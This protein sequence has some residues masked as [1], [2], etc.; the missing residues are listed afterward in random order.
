MKFSIDKTRKEL[1]L[2]KARQVSD[3]L[4]DDTRSDSEIY[5]AVLDLVYILE[6]VIK[7][8]VAEENFLLIYPKLPSE[9]NL[10]QTLNYEAIESQYTHKIIDIF[11][12]FKILFPDSEVTK[13]AQSIELLV[14]KRNEICHHIVA[15][16]EN[17]EELLQLARTV[18]G[19]QLDTLQSIVGTVPPAKRSTL[20]HKQVAELFE[21]SV[22]KKLE[23][24]KSPFPY[25]YAIEDN[26]NTMVVQ[27]AGIYGGLYVNDR[28]PRCNHYA[29]GKP[30][31][32][33]DYFTVSLSSK[34][35]SYK[36]TSCG[37][38]LTDE[39]YRV[40]QKILHEDR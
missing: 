13:N 12:S 40:A 19:A 10:K 30:R 4:N 39:E 26:L 35:E 14:Q 1:L 36:C 21:A 2:Q 37:L 22:R 34:E 3:I 25:M 27:P 28:C 31:P 20:T 8:K 5:T 24:K 33:M 9:A 32:T 29:F 11:R 7:F 16:K 18:Y 6:Q 15:I 17:T 23:M 38:E